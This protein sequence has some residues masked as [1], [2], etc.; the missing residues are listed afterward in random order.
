MKDGSR[1]SRLI[2]SKG[3][4][5][6][7]LKKGETV[8]NELNGATFS[9]RFK[10]WIYE[11]T[12]IRFNHHYPIVDSRIVQDMIKK[13]SYSLDTFYGFDSE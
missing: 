2:G 6:P 5:A 7:L 8:R 1:E 10:S 11:Q 12:G 13:D 4:L 3:K 9:A